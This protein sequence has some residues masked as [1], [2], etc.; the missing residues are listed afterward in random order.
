MSGCLFCNHQ[1]AQIMQMINILIRKF[2]STYKNGYICKRA[3]QFSNRKLK[4]HFRH[5]CGRSYRKK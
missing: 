2:F 4:S 5:L 1:N 3:T